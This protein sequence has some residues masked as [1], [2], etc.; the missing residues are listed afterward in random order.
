MWCLWEVRRR[1]RE[2]ER[3][4]VEE[5]VGDGVG[6]VGLC[7]VWRTELERCGL[8]GGVEVGMGKTGPV[9]VCGGGR[10]KGGGACRGM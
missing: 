2:W 8:C 6:E 3:G 7:G 4:S 5:G 9:V 10:R 1:D